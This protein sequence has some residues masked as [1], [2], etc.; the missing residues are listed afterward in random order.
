MSLLL[1]VVPGLEGAAAAAA[2]LVSA[3]FGFVEALR[4]L[5]VEH[6]TERVAYRTADRPEIVELTGQKRV[7]VM[8]YGD[9]VIH[10][11]KRIL[12]YL[13]YAHRANRDVPGRRP[14]GSP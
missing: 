9:E 8:V 2:G 13:D 5:G 1:P 4:K 3:G 12:E 10:D 6:R 7:P 11:S 14:G